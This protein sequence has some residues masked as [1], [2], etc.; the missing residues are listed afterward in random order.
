[1]TPEEGVSTHLDVNR[2]SDDPGSG[3]LVPVHWGTFVLGLHAWSEP[4]ERLCAAADEHG[5]R[6]AVPRPG[7]RVEVARAPKLDHWW[8]AVA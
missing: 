5:V 3:L 2:G 6:V 1:M 8:R 4:V 7:E